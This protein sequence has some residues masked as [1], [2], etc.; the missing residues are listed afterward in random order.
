MLIELA[1]ST[2]ATK[3][4]ALQGALTL[5]MSD[6][7][8]ACITDSVCAAETRALWLDIKRHVSAHKA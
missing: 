6:W 7:I 1:I 2:S 5:H 4:P 8:T 3:V